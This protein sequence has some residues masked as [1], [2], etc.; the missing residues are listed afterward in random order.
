MGHTLYVQISLSHKLPLCCFTHRVYP[1]RMARL[2]WLATYLDTSLEMG[3]EPNP[4]RTHRTR[5]LFFSKTNRTEPNWESCRTEPNPNYAA[6]VRF[7]KRHEFE[8]YMTMPLTELTALQ[9]WKTE[10][11]TL[12]RMT[13]IAKQLL[14]IERFHT[15]VIFTAALLRCHL[16]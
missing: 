7:M 9:F 12:P 8:K 4:N 10:Q 6:L 14:A 11:K 16:W 3:I 15:D 1:Q 2:S 13:A 5:T